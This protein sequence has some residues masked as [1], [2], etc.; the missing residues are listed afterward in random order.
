MRL[1]DESEVK[2]GR[3]LLLGEEAVGIQHWIV[4]G[5]L[6][7]DAAVLGV[8][9]EVVDLGSME[10]V[11]SGEQCRGEEED[12][13]GDNLE[14]CCGLHGVPPRG[15]YGLEGIGVECSVQ[16]GLLAVSGC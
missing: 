13:G 7:V 1:V 12:S 14:H 8:G 16:R 3:A 10:E 11:D 2:A 5:A 4:D 9:D 15:V 6:V